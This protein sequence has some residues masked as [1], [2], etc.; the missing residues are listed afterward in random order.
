MQ[1][2]R[3]R[4]YHGG[5]PDLQVILPSADT[6]ARCLADYGAHSVCR[7]DKVYV[8]TSF[9]GAAIYAS[10]HQSGRGMVYEVEPQGPLEPDPDFHGPGTDGVMSYCCLWARVLKRHRLTADTMQTVRYIVAT[11]RSAKADRRAGQP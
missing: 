8:V 2:E 4:Y 7:R 6:G 11:E 5:P 9:T 3:T 10:L 1:P